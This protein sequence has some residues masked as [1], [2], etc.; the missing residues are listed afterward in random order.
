MAR[1][2]T[3]VQWRS[4][5]LAGTWIQMDKVNKLS[6]MEYQDHG[7]EMM[8]LKTESHPVVGIFTQAT[9]YS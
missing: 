5:A 1:P 7:G 2:L 4:I 8:G 9:A 3:V 6:K